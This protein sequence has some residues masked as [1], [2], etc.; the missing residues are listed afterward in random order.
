MSYAIEVTEKN[1]AEA[2][3]QGNTPQAQENILASKDKVAEIKAIN[4]QQRVEAMSQKQ[5]A[6]QGAKQ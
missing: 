6:Q 5:T 3:A 4:N 1:R 2:R